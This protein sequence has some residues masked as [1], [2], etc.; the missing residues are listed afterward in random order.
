MVCPVAKPAGAAQQP[1][2]QL[3]Q[4]TPSSAQQ[5]GRSAGNGARQKKEPA[6]KE[7]HVPDTP[8]CAVGMLDV[9]G[10]HRGE[11]IN[12]FGATTVNSVSKTLTLPINSR[13]YLG[14]RCSAGAEHDPTA[15]STLTNIL[16]GSLSYTTDVSGCGCRCIGTFYLASMHQNKLASGMGD[17]Y[18]DSA[19]IGGV[20]CPE[21]DFQEANRHAWHSVVHTSHDPDGKDGG[22]GGGEW[23]WSGPR[24]WTKEK[25]GPGSACVDTTKPFRV[26]ASFP[27][28]PAMSELDHM[29]VELSQNGCS[30]TTRKVGKG[31]GRH[32]YTDEKMKEIS[33]ALR[34]G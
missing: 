12:A 13:A 6:T 18:C 31:G 3:E 34:T 10:H 27:V 21:I 25:Y 17:Y 4:K 29:L 19:G 14:T 1:E 20:H 22:Y 2:Q 8:R 23:S 32:S 28:D 11:V 26:K 5:N 33:A 30:I 9:K 24:D 16:G 7:P 15:Y